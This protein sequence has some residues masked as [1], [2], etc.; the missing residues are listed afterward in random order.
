MNRNLSSIIKRQRI[1]EKAGMSAEKNVYVFEIAQEA[2]KRSVAEAVKELYNVSPLKVG[3]V[4]IPSKQVFVR[5]KTGTRS[6]SK[7][8]YV[9]LKKGDKIE[10]V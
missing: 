2:T 10:I 9:Y 5:G 4:A 6:G 1:T 3:I 7:K 8:A